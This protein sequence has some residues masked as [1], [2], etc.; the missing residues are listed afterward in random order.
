MD[1]N[2][3]PPPQTITEKTCCK[4]DEGII[5]INIDGPKCESLVG[6]LGVDITCE[7]NSKQNLLQNLGANCRENSKKSVDSPDRS[8]V[9]AGEQRSGEKKS[10]LELTPQEN[11]RAQI[12]NYINTVVAPRVVYPHPMSDLGQ[13]LPLKK[14]G[15]ELLKILEQPSQP[16]TNLNPPKIP[17]EHS[18]LNIT[19]QTDLSEDPL[20]I[21]SKIQSKKIRLRSS[22]EHSLSITTKMLE[23]S[24]ISSADKNLSK[25]NSF[26]K[27][28]P[29]VWKNSKKHFW[30][31][32]KLEFPDKQALICSVFPHLTRRHD[33]NNHEPKPH[34]THSYPDN[35]NRVEAIFGDID[36]RKR[37]INEIVRGISRTAKAQAI[38]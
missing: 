5:E 37:Y 12:Q 23:S 36:S 8:G 35:I 1:G 3:Q 2:F 25:K 9:R 24:Q 22:P 34:T 15:N 10:H 21:S 14:S 13:N 19:I 7:E 11:Q 32:K 18:N 31:K 6:N 20:T 26:P 38:G 4:T 27:N 30:F 17:D 29:N 28:E 16:K 33:S